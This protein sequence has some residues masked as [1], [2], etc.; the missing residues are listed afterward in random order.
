ML[1]KK[2]RIENFKCI[3]SREIEI[4]PFDCLVGPNNS[5]KTTL[6]QALAL[7]DFCAHLC[8][9]KRNGGLEVTRRNVSP[10]DFYVLPVSS[11]VDLWTDKR[12]QARKKHQIISVTVTFDRGH[13]VKAA[14]DLT[15]NIYHFSLECSDSSDECLS[16]LSQFR[17]AYLPVF[18]TFLPQ[19]ERRTPAV[20]ED[21]LVRG[22]VN[23]VIRNLLLNLKHKE[24]DAALVDTLRR[25]FPSL[26]DITIT[27]DETSDR[28]IAVTYKEKGRTKEFDIFSAGS[29]FQQ[30]VY[31]FGFITLR[32]PHVILLDEPDVHLHGMLQR[33]LLD[34]LRRLVDAG[35][36]ILFATHSRDLISQ[37][38]PDE[39]LTLEEDGARRLC[40]ASDIY[41]T[42]DKLG[43]LDSTQLPTIQA[44]RRVLVVE[45]ETDRDIL[46]KGQD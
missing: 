15:F 24:Q 33:A 35:K 8:I 45:N 19:E 41:D 32:Q 26:K 44:F 36:Q 5:G 31:L 29:G 37:M 30:F 6:L 16:D 21:S 12:T 17:I 1:I 10:E 40:I 22:R 3:E 23:S 18:S 7:F 38:P 34:E 4:R 13:E 11:P 39:I 46:F 2:V 9:G 27:F 28:Y 25:S 43:S 42:L 14:L 20:I